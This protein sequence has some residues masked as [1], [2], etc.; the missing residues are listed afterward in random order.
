M[1]TEMKHKVQVT[2][3]KQKKKNSTLQVKSKHHVWKWVSIYKTNLPNMSRR[4]DDHK[5]QHA[6]CQKGKSQNK[7]HNQAAKMTQLNSIR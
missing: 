5:Q 7:F 4:M 2:E 3:I 6:I 1:K